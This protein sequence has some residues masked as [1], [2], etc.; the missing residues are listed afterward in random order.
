MCSEHLEIIKLSSFVPFPH[1]SG[2]PIVHLTRFLSENY[3]TQIDFVF[4]RFSFA[5]SG[6][7]QIRRCVSLEC[8]GIGCEGGKVAC[9]AQGAPAVGPSARGWAGEAGEENH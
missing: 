5:V 7:S 2:T 1:L 3:Q 4:Q 8:A 6:T 9:G